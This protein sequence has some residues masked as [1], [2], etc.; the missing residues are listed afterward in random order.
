VLARAA[1]AAGDAAARARLADWLRTTGF[2]DAVTENI[3]GMR[4]GG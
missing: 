4:R 1:T 2:A 3:L